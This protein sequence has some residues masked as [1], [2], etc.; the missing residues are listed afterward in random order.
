MR[1]SSCYRHAQLATQFALEVLDVF[2]FLADHHTRTRRVNGDAGV[3]G[4]TLDQDTRNRR[5]LELGLQVL[6]HLDVFRQHTGEITVIGIPT[7]GPV[8]ADRQ[9]KAGWMDFLSHILLASFSYQ[10]SRTHGTWVF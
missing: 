3:L 5:V 6:A 4:R 1:F 8:A 7:R 10:P 9:A 2:T